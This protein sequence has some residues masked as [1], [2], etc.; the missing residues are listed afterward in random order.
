MSQY[1]S[2]RAQLKISLPDTSPEVIN[3]L[4]SFLTEMIEGNYSEERLQEHIDSLQEIAQALSQLSGKKIKQGQRVLS[5]EGSQMGDVTIRDVAS[6]NIV[7]FN[8]FVH[9]AVFYSFPFPF[10]ELC[11]VLIL[12]FDETTLKEFAVE[13]G[14]NYEKLEG[15]NHWEKARELTAHCQEN[16]TL[17]RIKEVME[18]IP[19]GINFV[20]RLSDVPIRQQNSNSSTTIPVSWPSEIKCKLCGKKLGLLTLVIAFQKEL[21]CLPTSITLYKRDGNLGNQ[22]TGKIEE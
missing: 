14:V 19:E 2:L 4:C 9:D 15:T 22:G 17:D 10:S 20:Q 11:Q 1:Q 5:L 13:L 16:E 6:G 18:K 3:K 12:R 8:L 7:N 21:K